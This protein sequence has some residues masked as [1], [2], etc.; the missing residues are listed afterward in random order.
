MKTRDCQNLYRE[1]RHYDLINRD[2]SDDI[3]YYFAQMRRFGE[4]ILELASGTGRITIPAL[5]AG[6]EIMGL[7]LSMSMLCHAKK[8]AVNKRIR[9]NVICADCRSFALKQKFKLIIF[10]FNALTHIQD[11]ESMEAFL[12]CGREH[13]SVDGRFIIDVFNHRE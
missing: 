8:K 1:G 12:S 4:P 7:D 11:L 6:F 3:P 9:L 2:I 5:E 13:L 10:P